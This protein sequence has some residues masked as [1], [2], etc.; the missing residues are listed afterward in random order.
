MRLNDFIDANYLIPSELNL[1]KTSATFAVD[2]VVHLIGFIPNSRP[3]A[4]AQMKTDAAR[5]WSTVSL[6][7]SPMQKDPVYLLNAGICRTCFQKQKSP[8]CGKLTV[9][10]IKNFVWVFNATSVLQ[11]ENLLFF[12]FFRHAVTTACVYILYIY[13]M[14]LTQISTWIP[15]VFLTLR[16]RSTYM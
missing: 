13:I 4:D 16:S 2:K 6:F 5:D 3:V 10:N 8:A 1:H 11:M 7:D 15:N 9:P 12:R 14:D